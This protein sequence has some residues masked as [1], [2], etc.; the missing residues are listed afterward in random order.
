[1]AEAAALMMVAGAAGKGVGGIIQMREQQE[2]AKTQ[3][4][5]LNQQADEERFRHQQNIK[6]QKLEG[7]RFIQ[8][9]VASFAKAGVDV[10][11]GAPLSV[12]EETASTLA[13]DLA[14]SEREYTW[15]ANQLIFE[16]QQVKRS[17]KKAKQAGIIGLFTGGMVD[18]GKIS[19]E[20]QRSSKPKTEVPVKSKG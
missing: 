11:S 12:M 18:A 20:Y 5:L 7:Q 13:E 4:D 19:S 6:N 9:Q 10:G 15:R 2:A 16:Q 14:R 17:A 1:M 3:I 8:S